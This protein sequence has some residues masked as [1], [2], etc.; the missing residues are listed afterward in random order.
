MF[1]SNLS[2]FVSNGFLIPSAVRLLRLFTLFFSG[3]I[4]KCSSGWFYQKVKSWKVTT[5]LELSYG[6]KSPGT[7]NRALAPSQ[8]GML[9]FRLHI[10]KLS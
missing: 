7:A 3:A 4:L 5:F 6:G 10:M 9:M 1:I 8:C 2:H